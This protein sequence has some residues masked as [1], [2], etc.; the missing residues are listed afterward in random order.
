VIAHRHG[1]RRASRLSGDRGAVTAETAI[2]LPSLLV[3]T[4]VA[5]SGIAWAGQA[6]RCQNAAGE[7]ARAITREESAERIA[8]LERQALPSG[9][10][11]LRR[12][13]GNVV[14]V[15]VRWQPD[16]GAPVWVRLAPA[17]EVEAVA[18]V[19]A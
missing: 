4:A 17:I 14:R 18:L 3:V 7:V 12:S 13:D 8:E 1:R 19:Q 2:A 16:S 6:V 15:L 5:L 9:A 11:I 10:T